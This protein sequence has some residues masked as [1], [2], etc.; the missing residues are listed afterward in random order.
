MSNQRDVAKLA[1][2]SMMTVSRVINKNGYVKEETRIKVNEAIVKLEYYP[3]NLGRSL[4]NNK[5]NIIAVLAPMPEGAVENDPYFTRLLYGIETEL[6]ENSYDI[7]L[8][9]KRKRRVDGKSEFDYFRPFMERKADALILMG[10]RLSPSDIETIRKYDIPFCVIGDRPNS[11]NIHVLDTL[12]REG[13]IQLLESIYKMGHRE[14]AFGGFISESF[15]IVERYEG[16]REFL[17]THNLPFREEYVFEC[18]NVIDENSNFIRNFL[19]NRNKYIKSDRKSPTVI[20]CSTDNVAISAIRTAHNLGIEVPSELCISGF[21]GTPAGQLI[22]PR[23]TTMLQPLEKMGFRAANLTLSSLD[24]PD[25]PC[26]TEFFEVTYA[27]G[28]SVIPVSLMK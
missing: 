4:N 24:N 25:T 2:V 10:A 27:P 3:N 28:D 23:L 11:R 8:S 13:F 21:D 16:Y 6:M 22:Q 5:V 14:I 12:N 18:P 9:T 15:N 1:G 7:L 20:A 17:Q 26:T 19:E